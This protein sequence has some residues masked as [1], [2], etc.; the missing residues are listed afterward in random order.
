MII[1]LELMV[2]LALILGQ[3]RNQRVTVA[4]ILKCFPAVPRRFGLRQRQN[5]L[6]LLEKDTPALG[7]KTVEIDSQNH[8]NIKHNNC[9]QITLQDC[10]GI[11]QQFHFGVLEIELRIAE[12]KNRNRVRR[13]INRT[14]RLHLQS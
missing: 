7:R 5:L 3:R 13:I 8:I 2:S 6:R 1:V 4:I 12:V 10:F 9:R 11:F 14:T